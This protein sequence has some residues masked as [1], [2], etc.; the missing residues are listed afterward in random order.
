MA[1]RPKTRL[2]YRT[3]W[4]IVHPNPWAEEQ[5]IASTAADATT[6]NTSPNPELLNPWVDEIG[7]RGPLSANLGNQTSPVQDD[8]INAEYASLFSFALDG[9]SMVTLCK[10]DG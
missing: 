5:D 3:G 10:A 1:S 9:A 6:N 4:S 7:N 8:D 2:I